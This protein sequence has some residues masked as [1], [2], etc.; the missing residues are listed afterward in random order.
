MELTAEEEKAVATVDQYLNQ[1]LE[2]DK[3]VLHS[4]YGT[5]LYQHH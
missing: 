5:L 4:H 1:F 2:A 3:V